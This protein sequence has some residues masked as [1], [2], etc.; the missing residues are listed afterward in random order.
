MLEDTV[1]S[2]LK[3]ECTEEFDANIIVVDNASS[4]GTSERMRPYAERGQ[5]QLLHEIRPGLS[6]ARNAGVQAATGRWIIFLDDDVL[7]QTDFLVRYAAAMRDFPEMGYFSGAVKPV[8]DGPIPKWVE[9]VLQDHSWCFSA[10]DLGQSTRVLGHNQFPFGANMAIRRDIALQFP[11]ETDL[12]FKHGVL[13]PGEETALF[14]SVAEAG[15]QGMWI[16]DVPVLHRLPQRRASRAF[17]LRRAYGQGHADAVASAVAGSNSRWIFLELSRL[18]IVLPVYLIFNWQ[19][20]FSLA[21]SWTR[22]LGHLSTWIR[23]RLTS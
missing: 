14:R 17:L 23:S 18:T 3:C 2:L 19:K 13:I 12:G 1:N 22:C 10:T 20:S 15:Y 5:I 4:D 8:F 7:V 6:Y 21:V 11:F 9:I 16:A